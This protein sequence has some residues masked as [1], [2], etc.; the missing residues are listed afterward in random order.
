VVRVRDKTSD[1]AKNGEWLNFEMSSV[2]HDLVLVTRDIRVVLFVTIEV[3]DQTRS[4]EHIESCAASFEQLIVS[5]ERDGRTHPNV[6]AGHLGLAILDN[7]HRSTD[8]TAVARDVD[9]PV[10]MVAVNAN[11]LGS[12]A[13]SAHL[14]ECVDETLGQMGAPDQG[15]VDL[16][17]VDTTAIKF[18]TGHK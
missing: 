14:A 10:V 11:E 17:E 7:D 2:V 13:C 6:L 5:H 15:T 3:F 4:Q 12:T 9:S 18:V 16:D 1:S 8:P